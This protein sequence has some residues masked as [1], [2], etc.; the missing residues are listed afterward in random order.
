[1]WFRHTPNILCRTKMNYD[2]LFL[3]LFL[4]KLSVI[5]VE[6]YE[7]SSIFANSLCTFYGNVSCKEN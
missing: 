3:Q 1:M 7:Q 2:L 5:K 6:V 4:L